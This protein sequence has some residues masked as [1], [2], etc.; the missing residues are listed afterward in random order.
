MMSW[1]KGS[2]VNKP[3]EVKRVGR[4]AVVLTGS[5][6]LSETT[7]PWNESPMGALQFWPHPLGGTEWLEG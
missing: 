3:V 4:S 1:A 6:S 5:Q 7:D 2:V